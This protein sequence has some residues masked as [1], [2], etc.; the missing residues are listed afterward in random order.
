ME[1][2]DDPSEIA[3]FLT[4]VPPPSKALLTTREEIPEGSVEIR[5]KEFGIDATKELLRNEI[6]ATAPANWPD[7]SDRDIGTIHDATGGIPVAIKWVLGLLM[8]PNAGLE[9]VL[10]NLSKRDSEPLTFCFSN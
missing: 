7:L 5:L 2:V 10:R 1:T 3:A 6:A 8:R 4:R 9:D